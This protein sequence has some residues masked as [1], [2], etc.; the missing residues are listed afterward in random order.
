[1]SR[2]SVEALEEGCWRLVISWVRAVHAWNV[3]RLGREPHW[4]RL[5]NPTECA[6]RESLEATILSRICKIV[7]RRNM[8]QKD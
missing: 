6:R 1:M 5:S 2:M 8:T 4:L 3:L 7:W